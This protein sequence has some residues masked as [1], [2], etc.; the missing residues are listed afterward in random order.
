MGQDREAKKSP[1]SDKNDW[2]RSR[3]PSEM[4]SWEHEW[5]CETRA[6]PNIKAKTRCLSAPN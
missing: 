4:E 1:Y 3:F 5:D 6:S 2:S